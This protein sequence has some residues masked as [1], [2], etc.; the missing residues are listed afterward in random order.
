M[1]TRSGLADPPADAVALDQFPSARPGA[2]LHRLSEW[3]SAW[4]FSSVASV[5]DSTGGRF[6]LSRPSGTCY[7]AES[8]DGAIVET[9]LRTPVKVVVAERL[10][11]LFHAT[12]TLRS[13]APIADLTAAAATGFGLNAEI[14]TTLDYHTPRRWAH[15]LWTRRW[16]GLRYRLRGD[17]SGRAAGRAVFGSAGLHSRAPAGMST[18][19]VPI[20][21]EIAERVLAAR[22]VDVRPIPIQ[23]PIVR[24]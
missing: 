21:R 6:D 13:E 19:V 8:L 16:R 10:D 5:D 22:G 3:P 15:A 9:V 14:H 18:R 11:E 2:E 17:A 24:P 23:V 7:L 20:N 12:V 1:T 4:W